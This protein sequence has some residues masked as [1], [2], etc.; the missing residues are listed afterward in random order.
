MI[1]GKEYGSG[2]S[3]DWAAKGPNLLGV[4][5]AIAESYERIHRSNL[6]MMGIL[7]LQFRA[8]ETPAD[9]RPHRPRALRDRGARQRRSARG[10]RPR[11]RR[12][13]HRPRAARHTARAR[14][15]PPRRHPP[16]RPAPPARCLTSAPSGV[17]SSLE[18]RDRGASNEAEIR[19]V[20]PDPGNAGEGRSG[21]D[22]A[23]TCVGNRAR[24][25]PAAG[26]RPARHGP[27]LGEPRRLAARAR[28]RHLPRARALAAEGVPRDPRRQPDRERDARRRRD[29]RR[30]RARAGDGADAGAA[31]A[32][33][34][35]GA[36]G[37]ER[38]AV[39]RLGDLRAAD[40]RD[41]GRRALRRAAR[42][43][44]AVAVDARV[45]RDRARCSPGSARSTS[46]ASSSASSRCGPCSARCST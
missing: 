18:C 35:V 14:V 8:G 9:A 2:S 38:R 10:D 12:H 24:A 22:G 32:A 11:R 28:R 20:R 23:N 42:L 15:P 7:P 13:V 43:P 36:D 41:G 16:V 27:P 17:P 19:P 21:S 34:L 25:R 40:H 5:A 31:R 44:R 46:C 45:R 37:P 39:R 4:R 29:D 30:G 1:A 6:V 26:V 3:R 33:G